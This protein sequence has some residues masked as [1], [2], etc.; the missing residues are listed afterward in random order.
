MQANKR[1]AQMAQYEGLSG[2]ALQRA[3]AQDIRTWSQGGSIYF[4]GS[5]AELQNV[6][7]TYLNQQSFEIVARVDLPDPPQQLSMTKM[8]GMPGMGNVPGMRRM[9]GIGDTRRMG[10]M[11]RMPDMG[12]P[13]GMN[14][15]QPMGGLPGVGGRPPIGG[16]PGMGGGMGVAFPQG[17]KHLVIAKWTPIES[18]SSQSDESSAV[19]RQP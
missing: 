14:R 6:S 15:M 1:Q 16:P 3:T 13:P 7:G 4:V 8:G 5:E 19:R 2:L 12:G 9:P 11:P 18:A 17:E 10:D